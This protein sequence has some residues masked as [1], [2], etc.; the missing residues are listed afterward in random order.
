[1]NKLNVNIYCT[2]VLL[3]A[4]ILMYSLSASSTSFTAVT[5]N[6][7][8]AF[9]TANFFPNPATT[10]SMDMGTKAPKAIMY[11]VYNI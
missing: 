2:I 10:C 6:L 3:H 4:G 9:Q 5:T 7:G 1:M 8:N 11:I